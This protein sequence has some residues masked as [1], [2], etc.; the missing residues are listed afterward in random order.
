MQLTLIAP[1]AEAPVALAELK[2]HLRIEHADEDALIAAMASA[3]VKA[4]EA[5]A[6]LAMVAQT[7]RLSL[8]APPEG[9]VVLPKGPVFSLLSVANV[10]REGVASPV[11]SA[12]YDFAPGLNAR[13][14]VRGFL[15]RSELSVGGYRVDFVAGFADAASVPEELKLAVMM[16]AAHFYENREAASPERVFPAVIAADA[17]IAPYKQVRL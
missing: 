12:L 5:R 7:F 15:P 16:I 6:A 13:I 4:V 17:L 3:A 11:D 10:N 9:V 14:A 2:A 1:P 8:D